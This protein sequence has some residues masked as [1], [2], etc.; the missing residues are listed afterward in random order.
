MTRFALI[1]LAALFVA[2]CASAQLAIDGHLVLVPTTPTAT[3]QTPSGMTLITVSTAGMV[4]NPS[5]PSLSGPIDCRGMGALDA[6]G[7]PGVYS[8]VCLVADGTGDVYT[9]MVTQNM[10]DTDQSTWRV[11]DGTGRYAGASG[12]GEVRRIMQAADGRV[13]FHVTG[14]V[15]LAGGTN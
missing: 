10:A 4:H 3:T 13:A 7:A 1:A 8:T 9:V 12:G 5:N 6:S 2:P 11:I 15:A 14:T